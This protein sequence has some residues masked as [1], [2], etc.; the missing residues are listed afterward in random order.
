MRVCL[1][2]TCPNG[3]HRCCLECNDFDSCERLGKCTI[4]DDDLHNDCYENDEE[5]R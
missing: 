1:R 4:D 3:K 5:Q 2:S